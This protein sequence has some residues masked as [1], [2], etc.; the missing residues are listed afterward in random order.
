MKQPAL[1][2]L[3]IAF[4][5]VAT[6]M[7][8]GFASGREIWQF[9]GVFGSYGTVGVLFVAVLFALMGFMTSRIAKKLDTNDLG[10]VVVPGESLLLKNFMANFMAI[11]LFFAI[12]TMSAAGGALFY[13][14]FGLSRALGGAVIVT[15][16]IVT[17][18][19]GFERVSGVFRFIVPALMAIVLLTSVAV[20][21]QS[22]WALRVPGTAE[23]DWAFQPSP[24]AGSWPLAA[25]LYLS[26]NILGVIPILSTAAIRAK[27]GGH[28]YVG[29]A[30]GGLLLGLL[31][32]ILLAAIMTAPAL[33]NDADMPMLALSGHLP[34]AVNAVYTGALFCAIYASA[35]SCYYGF[36]IKMIKAPRRKIKIALGAWAGFALGLVGFTNVVAYLFPVA[37]FLGLSILVMLTVNY[38][39]TLR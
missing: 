28:A 19:G 1:G 37:G 10:K 5:Y 14:Q 21:V 15:L 30:L 9:F 27:S 34:A 22:G 16:V 4:L 6:I 36:T 24:L 31:A 23:P 29:S 12:V 7:G 18:I 2:F 20:I 11:M 39:H 35:T 3:N 32:F 26:Y 38:F 33:S 8:A 13:Q 25:I 17:V